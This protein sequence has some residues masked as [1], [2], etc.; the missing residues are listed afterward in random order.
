MSSKRLPIP[1][2]RQCRPIAALVAV[3]ALATFPHL[4]MAQEAERPPQFG[5]PATIPLMKKQIKPGVFL[6][7]G[8][9]GNSIVV[10]TS[11]GPVLID[12]KVMRESVRKEL[13]DVVKGIDPRPI[14]L[15]FVTHHHADH[16]GGTYWLRDMGV[17]VVGHSNLIPILQTYKSTIAPRNPTPPSITFDRDYRVTVGGV[18]FAAYH[19][20]PAHTNADIAIVL[21]QSKIVVTGD[22]IV[23]DGEPDVDML[24][25]HG[26]LIGMQQRL[27]DLLKLDFELAIPGHGENAITRP[28]VILYKSRIDALI[29]RGKAAVRQ[30]VGPEG[31]L[32]AMRSDD[33]GFRLVGHFWTDPA[34]LAPIYEELRGASGRP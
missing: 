6:I 26:S 13:V 3:L 23:T 7:T 33:L 21:P 24:D 17:P 30:G 28:E 27:N 31:L 1:V 16:G 2:L 10:A 5:S 15:A 22:L 9:G 20:G 8:R 32:E 29:A 25:G 34:R 12:D 18:P 4:A 14:K 19:W 11:D